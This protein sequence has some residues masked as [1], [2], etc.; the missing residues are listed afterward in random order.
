M[1]YY[2]KTPRPFLCPGKRTGMKIV[3]FLHKEAIIPDLQSIDKKGVIEE[4]SL[5]VSQSTDAG[6]EDIVRVLMDREHLGSTGIGGGIGIPH[7]KLKQLDDLFVGFGLSKKGV[8]FDSLDG[9]PTHI[10]FLL[11]TPENSTGQHLKLLALI[12]KILKNE[13]FKEKL[14]QA[15]DSNEIYRIIEEEESI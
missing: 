3:D 4:M 8:D 14:L 9:R 1:C 7:G 13:P 12:S 5:P 2:K 15:N 11:L 6:F 10:F